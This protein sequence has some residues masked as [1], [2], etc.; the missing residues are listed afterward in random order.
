M[1]PWVRR[2]LFYGGT[3]LLVVVMCQELVRDAFVAVL[4]DDAG[5]SLHAFVRT[6]VEA[7][8]TVL[9]VALYLDVVLRDRSSPNPDP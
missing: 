9:F 5:D 3:L 1:H 4:G 2:A 8:I 6:N 7:P